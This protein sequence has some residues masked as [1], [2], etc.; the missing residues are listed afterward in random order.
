MSIPTNSGNVSTCAERVARHVPGLE[1]LHRMAGILLAER[2]PASGR[3]LVL[4]AGGG[5]ELRAFAD[6]QP[7]WQ[8]DAVD[9]S[10]GMLDQARTVLSDTANRVTES[11]WV[12]RRRVAHSRT[13]SAVVAVS[14]R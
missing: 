1:D 7:G 9:P 10:P 4:G 11:H 14:C 2:V 5:L 13:G 6:W 3:V 12:L 8:F